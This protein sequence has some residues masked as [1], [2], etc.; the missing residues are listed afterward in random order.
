MKSKNKNKKAANDFLGDDNELSNVKKEP[1][2][3]MWFITKV[4]KNRYVVTIGD[5]KKSTSTLKKTFSGD[6]SVAALKDYVKYDMKVSPNHIID[7]S[8]LNL[9][10]PYY[11]NFYVRNMLKKSNTIEKRLAKV[12]KNLE[13]LAFDENM[14]RELYLYIDNNYEM[15]KLKRDTYFANLTRKMAAG[16]YDPKLAVKFLMYLMQRGAEAYVKEFLGDPRLEE[17]KWFKIFDKETRLSVA[18][19][20]VEE[21]EDE[22]KFGHLDEFISKKYRNKKKASLSNRL[23]KVVVALD[24]KDEFERILSEISFLEVLDTM[25]VSEMVRSTRE[26]FNN[27]DE[28]ASE[29]KLS[30]RERSEL[31]ELMNTTNI[32]KKGYSRIREILDRLFGDYPGYQRYFE[33]MKHKLAQKKM[34]SKK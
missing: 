23:K 13:K 1:A 28:L 2:D 7:N 16:K 26:H 33:E 19:E 20:F 31:M 27:L 34:Q 17:N 5:P 3:H 4:G 8:G 22:Y 29:S 18:K 12:A 21:F 14:A 10:S 32:N 9:V 11:T 24:K 6:D 25:S 15:N 30:P